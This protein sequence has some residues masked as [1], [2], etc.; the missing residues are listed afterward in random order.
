MKIRFLSAM[1]FITVL[2]LSVRVGNI[3]DDVINILRGNVP[4]ENAVYVTSARAQSEGDATDD[5]PGTEMGSP[6]EV[7]IDVGEELLHFFNN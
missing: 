2:M 3:W 6:G 4:V 7:R 1:I 5:A